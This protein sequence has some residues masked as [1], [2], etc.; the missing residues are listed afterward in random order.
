MGNDPLFDEDSDTGEPAIQPPWRPR[1]GIGAL[2]LI[3]FIFC[4]VFTMAYYT[5]VSPSSGIF[6]SRFTFIFITLALPMLLLTVL[7]GTRAVLLWM[8]KMHR[9]RR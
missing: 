8:D 4:A 2:M 6:S 7:S 1:F 3:T 9:R 5:S